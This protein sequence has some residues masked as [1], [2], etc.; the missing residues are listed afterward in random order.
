MHFDIDYDAA[1]RQA[2][3]SYF[4]AVSTDKTVSADLIRGKLTLA[5]H[6]AWQIPEQIVWDEDPFCQRNWVAQ[7]HMLR[8]LDPVRRVALNNRDQRA[9][10]FWIKTVRS[11][12]ESNKPGASKSKYAWS[13]MMD[14]IRAL[15]LCFGL[16]L[17][18]GTDD[19]KWL[20]DA[21]LQHGYW[22]EDERH[23]GHSNHALHQHQGLLVC[24]LV[25]RKTEWVTLAEK[26]MM[27]LFRDNYDEQG[28]NAEG[29]IGYHKNNYIWWE[30]AFKRFDLEG[31][32][33]PQDAERLTLALEELAYATK[34]NLQFERIGDI[35]TGG[36]SGLRSPE[37]EFVLSKGASGTPPVENTKI[38]DGGYVFGRSGW[39]QFERDFSDEFFYS[40]SF[41]SASRVHGHQDGGSL[42][43]HANGHPWLIDAGKYAYVQDEMRDYCMSRRGHN[44]IDIDDRPYDPNS[45]VELTRSKLTSELEDFEFVDNGYQ[46]VSLKRRVVYSRG[47]DFVIVIDTVRSDSPVTAHQRWH[48]DPRTTLER[49]RWG[50]ALARDSGVASIQW[51]GTTPKVSVVRGSEEPLDGWVATEWM[52]K[53]AT[54][55]VSASRQGKYF[56][57]VAVIGAS[58]HSEGVNFTSMDVDRPHLFVNVRSGRQHYVVE[59]GPDNA[60]LIM[61]LN[62]RPEAGADKRGT[63]LDEVLGLVQGELQSTEN[64]APAEPEN[65]S[66]EYWG[67]LRCWIRKSDNER[68]ARLM[69]LERLLQMQ[70][71]AEKSGPD[72]G[73][74]AA[75]LDLA[76][77]DLTFDGQISSESLGMRREPLTLW[78]G[79]GPISGTYKMPLVSG[80]SEVDRG[81]S[82]GAILISEVGGLTL[83]IAVSRGTGDILSVRFHGAVDRTRTSL[84]LFQG[85]TSERQRGSSFAIFQDPT[86]DLDSDLTLGWYL[87]RKENNLHQHMAA[88]IEEI[89]IS[90]G[91]KNVVLAGSSGGGFAAL[92]VGSYLPDSVVLALNPQTSV[93]RYYAA[94]AKRA[95]AATFD[96]DKGSES[97]LSVLERYCGLDVLPKIVYVQNVKDS[98]HVENHMKPFKHLLQS[99]Q[100]AGS[101]HVEFIDV[102]WGKGH[103]SA[104][105]EL[106]EEFWKQAVSRVAE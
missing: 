21:I 92:Q 67:E 81:G 12:I 47:G 95:V 88:C 25:L 26:R 31:I 82:K 61:G 69:G 91:I 53:E 28:V 35:D 105:P 65:Y 51:R 70:I 102:D 103:K 55:V 83:P 89:R 32:A 18:A 49:T 56:R 106:Y 42:T 41:G 23:L 8:W 52:K 24:G 6:P 7:L 38:Y 33:R 34:P 80:I 97:R 15:E 11:W 73:R 90:L 19:E 16:P 14:G 99:R 78:A 63:P 17:V 50:F 46:G 98:Y 66:V 44:V 104:T 60:Q 2:F 86:L 1:R 75:I 84:P 45:M 13:N 72:G 20:V 94:P 93:Q 87:G 30:T 3:G 10:E 74:R 39:G 77:Q 9:K 54:N 85:L 64:L 37:I 43:V 76:G 58:S 62:G 48:L 100:D 68:Q 27:Q 59:V 36:P 71:R 40:L 22:I 79:A 96:E 29:S 4:N 101:Q 5:P 57:M